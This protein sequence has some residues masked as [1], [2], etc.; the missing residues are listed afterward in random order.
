MPGPPT[1]NR[2]SCGAAAL[3]PPPQR[4]PFMSVVLQC[5]GSPSLSPFLQTAESL[6]E[7][8][9]AV[10]WCAGNV[11]AAARSGENTATAEL[12]L[13]RHW[14]ALLGLLCGGA[15]QCRVFLEPQP[16][17]ARPR[18]SHAWRACPVPA[19]AAAGCAGAAWLHLIAPEPL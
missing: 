10:M 19:G 5:I 9:K 17:R 16:R 4:A 14:A 3:I 15:A 1:L 18:R 12:C 7:L 8:V 6:V 11:A 2:G 13:V